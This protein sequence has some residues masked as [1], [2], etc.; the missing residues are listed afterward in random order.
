MIQELL[1][2]RSRLTSPAVSGDYEISAM[3]LEANITTSGLVTVLCNGD[4]GDYALGGDGCR[5]SNPPKARAQIW[6]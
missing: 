1:L 6:A 3:P 4:L 5:R 2:A